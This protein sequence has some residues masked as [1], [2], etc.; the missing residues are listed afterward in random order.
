MLVGRGGV[1]CSERRN[2]ERNRCRTVET[3]DDEDI[4]VGLGEQRIGAR[5]VRVR[6]LMFGN[7]DYYD[8]IL[9]ERDASRQQDMHSSLFFEQCLFRVVKH[10]E[11]WC[12]LT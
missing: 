5:N 9:T 6:M 2:R 4:L 8:G 10:V 3:R 7:K 11:I 1:R 12:D